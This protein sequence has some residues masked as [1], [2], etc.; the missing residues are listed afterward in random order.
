VKYIYNAINII[1]AI[2]VIVSQCG[3]KNSASSNYTNQNFSTPSI[4]TTHNSNALPSD[5]QD[6]MDATPNS[7]S[8][9]DDNRN[10]ITLSKV[11]EFEGIDSYYKPIVNG[12]NVIICGKNVLFNISKD[13]GKKN[14]ES[15]LNFNYAVD[16]YTDSNII[17]ACNAKGFLEVTDVNTGN[18]L[19]TS[20][21]IWKPATSFWITSMKA[22][23]L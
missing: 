22:M 9:N 11:W 3:C 19:W 16:F 18:L 21:L 5:L 10:N 23:E 17:A 8:S 20:G 15:F 13:T 12:N 1:I 2:S 7:P 14:Y 6:S 4:Q